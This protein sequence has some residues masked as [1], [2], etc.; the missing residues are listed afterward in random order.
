VCSRQELPRGHFLLK[1]VPQVFGQTVHHK[2]LAARE[3]WREQRKNKAR[4]R[5][6][7][8]ACSE[9]EVM[10]GTEEAMMRS[11]SIVVRV[12]FAG[13]TLTRDR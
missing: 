7:R 5:L 13:L 1:G 12:L 9:R 2:S 6:R 8:A 3:C 11:V 10:T 4:T